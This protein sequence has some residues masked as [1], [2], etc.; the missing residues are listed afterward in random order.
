MKNKIK[1]LVNTSTFKSN[2]NEPVPDFINKL[3]DNLTL[4]NTKLEFKN[5]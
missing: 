3:L 1:V 5:Q 4:E 2:K